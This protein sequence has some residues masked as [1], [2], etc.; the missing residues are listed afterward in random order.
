MHDAVAAR[1]LKKWMLKGWYNEGVARRYDLLP[2]RGVLRNLE[3]R[4][5]ILLFSFSCLF[6]SFVVDNLVAAR[7]RKNKK[8]YLF[9]SLRAILEKQNGQLRN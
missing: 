7:L 1:L 6:V 3:K 4:S 8:I 5:N 2:L 9:A